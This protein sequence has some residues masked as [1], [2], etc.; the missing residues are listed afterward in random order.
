MKF[1]STR[2]KTF[3]A[4][5]FI[6]I[7]VSVCFA[8]TYNTSGSGGNWANTGTWSGGVVPA[9]WGTHTV[10]INANVSLTASTT[11]LNGF[12]AINLNA[13]RSFTSGSAGTPNN[14]AM[15]SVNFNVV[16][17]VMTVY[18]DLTLNSSTNLNITSGS[19]IVTGTLNLNG[20]TLSVANGQSV[21]LGG[22]ILSS[23]GGTS[24]TNNGNITVNGNVSQSGPITNSS[25]GTFQVNGNHTMV[26]TGSA[27]FTNTGRINV[28][29]NLTVP[30]AAKFRVNPDGEA[31][32][33]GSV[34]AT[35]N[36]NLIIGTNVNPPPYAEM[37]IRQNLTL[38]GGDV[39]I[40]RNGR[41]AV[42][43]NVTSNTNGGTIFTINSG[44]QVYVDGNMTFNGGGD[45]IVNG[46]TSSPYGLY[47][48]GTVSYKP[49]SGSG[50][51]GHPEGTVLDMYNE[52]RPFYDWV[53]G[54]PGGPLPIVL[55]YFKVQESSGIGIYLNWMT[56]FEKNFGH[57]E[58][59]RAGTDL[60]FQTIGKLN[61]KGGLDINTAY[62]F[63][64]TYPL[65]GRNYYR[66]K[67][68]DLDGSFEYSTVVYSNWNFAKP[69]VV[70]P[71]PI[72]DNSFTLEY[73][74]DGD[75]ASTLQILDTR[76]NLVMNRK[77]NGSTEIEL[78]SG[79]SS[80]LYF[81]RIISGDNMEIIKVVIP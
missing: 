74:A 22:L 18:G 44:G 69:A 36:Q 51:T 73:D 16:N 4:A 37:V 7:F 25:T 77:V 11:V 71:N 26:N 21:T 43:G 12:A 40:D 56:T 57:F 42:F 35:D 66:L 58:I 13:G 75:V 60:D 38:N 29:G 61:G 33:D 53:A 45:H 24:L 28:T 14:L 30:G 70:Y 19:L 20:G 63:L 34:T 32:I 27:V 46:N 9:S 48:D 76:G 31:Y 41:L 67:S 52:S 15:Q 79:V 55:L 47:T 3:L 1:S 50:T 54:I 81:L 62:Q 23:S 2:S 80:G 39:L 65:R 68:I 72:V 49:N 17:G 59:Q 6:F 8:A 78:P 64:D 5:G 10:N